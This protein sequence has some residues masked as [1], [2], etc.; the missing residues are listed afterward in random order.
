[1]DLSA[2][3][4]PAKEA[5]LSILGATGSNL[6]LDAA[7]RG[8]KTR[9]LRNSD[10]VF[11]EGPGREG[12]R[13]RPWEAVQGLTPEA[14]A[15]LA[16]KP[17]AGI[18]RRGATIAS[19]IVSRRKELGVE[20]VSVAR[21]DERLNETRVLAVEANEKPRSIL[22]MTRI[23]ISLAL[24]DFTLG[25]V[26]NGGGDANLAYRLREL[27]SGRSDRVM[28][29]SAVMTLS[30]AAWVISTWKRLEGWL[31]RRA[32]KMD[33]PSRIRLGTLDR[34]A[35]REGYELAHRARDLFGLDH[36]SPVRDL[37]RLIYRELRV[38]VVQLRSKS[39]FTG[40]TILNNGDRGIVLNADAYEGNA[41]TRRMTLAHEL[42][43]LLWDTDEDLKSLRVD[44][45]ESVNADSHTVTDLIEARANAFAAEFLA[46]QEAVVAMFRNQRER[47]LVLDYMTEFFGVGFTVL[48]WQLRNS[49]PGEIDRSRLSVTRN[50]K[51]SD[52]W[53]AE[54]GRTTDYFVFEQTPAVRT[55]EFAGIVAEC[56]RRNLISEDTVHE[57]LKL[58]DTVMVDDHFIKKVQ[59]IGALV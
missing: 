23:S 50:N 2:V 59:A 47:P 9:L 21:S 15:A 37:D 28:T 25:A 40:A 16:E 3:G 29:P 48:S 22:W 34:L 54:V 57:Y 12:T 27:Q 42:G 4:T 46:P 45:D 44:T 19:S 17:A 14:V 1:M 43:H 6:T 53:K 39:R 11:L 31:G 7:V 32:A 58:P 36:T 51:P 41:W 52:M 26:E 55:G 35:F 33:N 8:S 56:Y 24:Q 30:E 49:L 38:P 13:L 10:H 20:P 5:L 18:T